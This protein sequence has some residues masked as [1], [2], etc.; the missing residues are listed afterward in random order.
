MSTTF[1]QN[2]YRVNYSNS[3]SAIAVGAVVVLS[4]G[5]MKLGIAIAAIAATT[6]TGE[7]SI[8][9]IHTLA[10]KTTDT[11]VLG[12]LIYWDASN[13]RLTTT[14]SGNTVAGSAASV[15][16]NTD[17]TGRVLLNNMPG[18]G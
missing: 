15:G 13:S 7:L 6:G 1:Y 5:L 9:G 8:S 18:P 17:T 4:T 16:A 14:S 2:G 10:K 11:W 3:G 12:Q